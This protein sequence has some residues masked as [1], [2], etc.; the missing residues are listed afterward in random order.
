VIVGYIASGMYG[1]TL[2]GAVGL[3][4]VTKPGSD[5]GVTGAYVKAGQYEI[6]VAGRRI[7]AQAALRP[8]YDPASTRVRS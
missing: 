6:E 4:Y 3:G 5:T 1:H 2:G 7:A 8:L